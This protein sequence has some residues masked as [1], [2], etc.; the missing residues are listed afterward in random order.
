MEIA[1]LV[2]NFKTM[3]Y[4]RYIELVTM[5]HKPSC[6]CLRHHLA[7]QVELDTVAKHW[8]LELMMLV[9]CSVYLTLW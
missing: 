4:V 9:W 1:K 6:I 8:I 7:S 5:V 3:V 2:Y